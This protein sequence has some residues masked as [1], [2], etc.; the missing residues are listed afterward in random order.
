MTIDLTSSVDTYLYL[1]QENATSGAA[2]HEND[3]HQGST[4]ASQ[5]QETLAAG[6][7]TVEAT[8]N[9]AGATGPFTLTITVD[10]VEVVS[11]IVQRYD[12]DPDGRIDINEVIVAIEDYQA[13]NI[14]INEV[15][16]VIEAYQSRN[17]GSGTSGAARTLR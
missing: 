16:A 4:S 1:R 15:I 3:N 8:T 7:Y 9:S 13:G 5:I 6:T 10:V 14:D 12:T 2:L 11:A 17:R